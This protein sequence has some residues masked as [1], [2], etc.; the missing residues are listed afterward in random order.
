MDN[1]PLSPSPENA[2]KYSSV[3]SSST[4]DL[5]TKYQQLTAHCKHNIDNAIIRNNFFGNIV[6]SLFRMQPN[7]YRCIKK[8][9]KNTWSL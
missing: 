5:D 8:K 6:L 9:K 7:S 1:V 3:F 2:F 4:L